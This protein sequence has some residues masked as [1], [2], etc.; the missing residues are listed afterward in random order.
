MTGSLNALFAATICFVG[1]H[2][3]LSS[4]PLRRKLAGLLGPGGFLTA[5]SLV[6]AAAFVW[7]MAAYKAA[8]ELMVWTPPAVFAWI[9]VALMPVAI[10]LALCG[11]TTQNPTL[12]GAER[13]IAE[14]TGTHAP[15]IISVTR[16]PFLWGTALWA[17]AHLAVNGDA[18]SIV[19]L[20]GILVLS[21]GG[22]AHIDERRENTLGAAWGPVKLTT[23][24]IPFAAI[25][26]G[27]TKLDWKGIGWWRPLGAIAIYLA[28]ARGHE[29][30]VGV[31][32][33]VG[34]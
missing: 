17:G 13:T 15:G 11:V 2:F 26:S 14:S 4:H 8:P 12:V 6:V 5:Y 20:G 32:V 22:M 1:A 10:F 7:M 18:A 31:P 29:W 34:G 9:P 24:V 3:L 21:L 27:R 28:L 30:L 16:H 25:A 23:G 19:V 33:M